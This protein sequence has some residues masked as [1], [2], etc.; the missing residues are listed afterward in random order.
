MVIW[1]IKESESFF[2]QEIGGD[3]LIKFARRR[4]E[5]FTGRFLLKMLSPTLPIEDILINKHGKPFVKDPN[6]HF[7]ISHSFPYVGVI[8]SKYPIGIDVQTYREKIVRIRHKFLSPYEQALFGEDIRQITLAWAAKEA[9]FK[10]SEFDGFDLINHL[11]IQ[12]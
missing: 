4:L 2:R 7:S 12:A 1:E 3:C 10:W 8:L 11:P 9:A 6:L 5:F